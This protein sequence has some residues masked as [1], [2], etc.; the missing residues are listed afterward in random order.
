MFTFRELKRN[1]EEVAPA[2]VLHSIQDI[3]DRNAINSCYL[4]VKQLTFEALHLSAKYKLS[5]EVPSALVEV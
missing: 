2:V 5:D 1:L 4:S 3:M